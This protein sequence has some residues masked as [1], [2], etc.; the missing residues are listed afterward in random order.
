MVCLQNSVEAATQSFA[1]LSFA[2]TPQSS[3]AVVLY[4]GQGTHPNCVAAT[5][6]ALTAIMREPVQQ[7][8]AAFFQD[9]NW[10][11]T[12]KL[13]VIPGGKSTDNIMRALGPTGLSNIAGA[14]GEFQVAYLGICAGGFIASNRAEYGMS[15]LYDN[16]EEPYWIHQQ[17]APK[18]FQGTAA[19]PLDRGTHQPPDQ[20]NI[21]SI[22]LRSS[23][24]LQSGNCYYNCGPCFLLAERYPGVT[25]LGEYET[26]RRQP[27]IIHCTQGSTS[28][29]RLNAVLCGVHPEFSSAD[30]I[31]P[32]TAAH[33]KP[34]FTNTLFRTMLSAL[35][36]FSGIE[37][38][39]K[40]ATFHIYSYLAESVD[41]AAP[42]LQF[43]PSLLRAETIGLEA[44][45]SLKSRL[46]AII[47]HKRY[48]ELPDGRSIPTLESFFD[49]YLG[50][51]YDISKFDLLH[52]LEID[53]PKPE[54]QPQKVGDLVN[55]YFKKVSPFDAKYNA[56]ADFVRRMESEQQTYSFA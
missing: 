34:D 13:I 31:A 26:P 1:Q 23:E 10:I 19:G 41:S 7:K 14:V 40:N 32:A 56:I 6:A 48:V 28:A 54:A 5:A 55:S 16:P 20:P 11:A 21:R 3:K 8:D 37:L 22:A 27:A 51:S 36:L 49:P 33:I 53:F 4:S 39:P 2:A 42:F 38:L 24:G 44:L 9:R 18:L 25:V 47:I 29:T 17:H 45:E 43:L 52:L 46:I 50:Y 15:S 30:S 35:G 12:T